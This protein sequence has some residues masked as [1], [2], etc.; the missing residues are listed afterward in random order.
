MAVTMNDV[1]RAAGVSL[2]TVSNVLNDYEFIRPATKQ[3]VLDAIAELGYEANLTARSLRSGKTRMLGLV[4]SDLAAPYYAELASKLMKAASARGYRVL[5]EQ[6]A[7]RKDNELSALKGTFRQLTDGLLFTPLALNA[8]DIA[9]NS[10]RKPVVMLGEHID[11]PRFDLVTMKNTE[12]ASA[13]TAHLLSSGRRRVVILGAAHGDVGGSNGLRLTGYRGALAAAEAD[14][15][16]ALVVPCEWRRDAGAAAVGN[17]LDSDVKFDA[18]FGLND[19]VALGAL[20]ELIIRGVKVPQDVALA[21]FD[22]IE[23]AR[24]AS[25]SLTTVAPGMDEIAERSVG[26]LIDRIEGAETSE[27]AIHIEAGFELKVRE[28]APGKS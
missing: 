14:Y 4:L 27:S 17:L 11:D 1:A 22:D 25:P 15:D 16:P 18:I 21:G 7:A 6:S 9:A 2:K 23:E 28:S 26:L 20:H 24:F 19:A 5:V 3:K 12:A 13:V 8:D 10:G